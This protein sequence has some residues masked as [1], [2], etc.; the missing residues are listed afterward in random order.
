MQ[1]LITTLK[2]FSEIF[3]FKYHNLTIVR[4]WCNIKIKNIH[5]WSNL[6][7]RC[8]MC[9]NEWKINFRIF[10]ILSFWDIII[11]VLKVGNFRL[12]FSITQKIK[13]AKIWNIIF[14]SF[15]HIAHL[16]CKYGHF[17]R[18]VCISFLGTGPNYKYNQP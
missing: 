8:G 13:I 10:A 11:F 16:S 17:W 12:I 7:K 6:H 9:R 15:Q 18:G 14:H 1:E 4:L 5:K 2:V 3:I